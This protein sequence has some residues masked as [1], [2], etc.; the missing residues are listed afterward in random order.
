M[1]E[2]NQKKGKEEG[3]G[4]GGLEGHAFMFYESMSLMGDK[5]MGMDPIKS[6]PPDSCMRLKVEVTLDP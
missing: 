3:G 6:P 5:M 1:V 2:E 4:G